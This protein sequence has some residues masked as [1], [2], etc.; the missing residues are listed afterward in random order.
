MPAPEATYKAGQ[1]QITVW[2]NTAKGK[3]GQSYETLSF[4]AVKNYKQGDDYKT[5]SNFTIQDLADL[6]ILIALAQREH[7]AKVVGD[8]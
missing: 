2:K 8:F 7:R 3:N 4:N 6:S 5:T 1:T